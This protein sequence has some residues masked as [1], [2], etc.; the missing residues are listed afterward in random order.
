MRFVAVAVMV[1]TS[2]FA[3]GEMSCAGLGGP[4]E[5]TVT[6]SI[7]E[8]PGERGV[9]RVGC[10]DWDAELSATEATLEAGWRRCGLRAWRK[11]G[12]LEVVSPVVWVDDGVAAQHVDFELPAGPIGGLGMEIRALGSAVQVLR[13]LPDTPAEAVG[14]RAGDRITEVAG[15]STAYMGGDRFVWHAT[16]IP[17]TPVDFTV[18][19][20]TGEHPGCG[21]SR[22]LQLR[23]LRERILD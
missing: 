9:L 7:P 2:A 1:G 16:G 19:R 4:D 18:E 23:A 8:G 13:V 11:D 14:L 17:G 10:Q 15:E 22:T 6:W 12:R 20:R 3:D 21:A 5:I